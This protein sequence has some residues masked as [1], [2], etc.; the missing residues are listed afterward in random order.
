M[1]SSRRIDATLPEFRG[2]MV[3]PWLQFFVKTVR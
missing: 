3:V 2:L 1:T